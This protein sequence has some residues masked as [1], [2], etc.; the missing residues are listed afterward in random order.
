MSPSPC[1]WGQ[2]GDCDHPARPFCLLEGDM[3]P[4]PRGS[5][6]KAPVLAPLVERCPG[7]AWGGHWQGGA[8]P[9]RP[10]CLAR[11]LCASY[12]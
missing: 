9:L 8:C 5:T 7:V 2:Q 6:H 10:P 3:S 1:W 4:T 11:E 12:G